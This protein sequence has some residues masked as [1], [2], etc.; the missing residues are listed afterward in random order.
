LTTL[1][2]GGDADLLQA[3]FFEFADLEELDRATPGT[4]RRLTQAVGG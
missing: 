4:K 1:A 3:V 2:P